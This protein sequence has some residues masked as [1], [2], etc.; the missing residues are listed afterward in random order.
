MKQHRR[1]YAWENGGL[2]EI[3][4]CADPRYNQTRPGK[5]F[6]M[7]VPRTL[8][9]GQGQTVTIKPGKRER[10]RLGL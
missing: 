9:V 6:G 1:I 8:P 7:F 10:K 3:T 5:K 2:V 4:D